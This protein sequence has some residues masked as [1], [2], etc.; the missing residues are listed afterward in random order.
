MYKGDI[1]FNQTN[2]DRET[3]STVLQQYQHGS[4][5]YYYH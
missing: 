4:K 3:T 2:G 1:R 5:Q